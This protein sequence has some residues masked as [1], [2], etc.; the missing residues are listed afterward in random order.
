MSMAKQLFLQTLLTHGNTWC[1]LMPDWNLKMWGECHVQQY[2]HMSE[3]KEHCDWK[4][5]QR[6][7][8]LIFDF[9]QHVIMPTSFSPQ[10]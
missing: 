3:K 6:R 10:V 1:C 9:F 7:K 8:I 2:V 5:P 4:Q